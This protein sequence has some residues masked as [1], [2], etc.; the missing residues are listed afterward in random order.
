MIVSKG[1]IIV[2]GWDACSRC[3]KNSH[4]CALQYFM[5]NHKHDDKEAAMTLSVHTCGEVPLEKKNK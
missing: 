3:H 1:T 2:E 5:K 4:G